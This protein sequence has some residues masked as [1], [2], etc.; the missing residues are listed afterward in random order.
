[1]P[2][3][4]YLIPHAASEELFNLTKKSIERFT[5]GP[6]LV[7]GKEIPHWAQAWKKL[8][9]ECPTDIGIFMD[10]DAILT[11]DITPLIE[12]VASDQYDAVGIEGLPP[13]P[14]NH[15]GYFD[16]NFLVVNIGKFK[17]E[18][19]EPY[20]DM[21]QARREIAPGLAIEPYYGVSQKLRGRIL[22]LPSRK[23]E[24]GLATDHDYVT[25]LWYGAWKHRQAWNDGLTPEYF[26]AVE[27]KFIHDHS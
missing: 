9:D 15:P 3:F 25:H 7:V 21:E 14:R 1:M 16:S 5:P 20:T 18:H 19:G 4:T 10:D 8:W 11:K 24:W 2:E 27:R 13:C 6:T 22:A 17:R 12:L 26:E 23:T